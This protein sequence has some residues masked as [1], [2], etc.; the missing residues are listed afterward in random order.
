MCVCCLCLEEKKEGKIFFCV[1]IGRAPSLSRSLVH[2]ALVYSSVPTTE[3]LA[4]TATLLFH[5]LVSIRRRTLLPPGVY[6]G[7]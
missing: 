2:V 4:S 1:G 6:D 5:F 3:A 7:N